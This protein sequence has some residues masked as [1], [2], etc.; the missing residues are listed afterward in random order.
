MDQ[1]QMDRIV[2]RVKKLFA[3][4]G[5]NPNENEAAAA[6]EK[7]QAILIE[8]NLSMTDITNSRIDDDMVIDQELVTSA[9]PW[10]RMLASAVAKMYFCKYYYIRMPGYKAVHN[11]VGE[12]HNIAVAKMMFIYLDQQIDRLAREGAKRFPASE[13]S[14]YRS[15]FRPACSIRVSDRIDARIEAA[16]RGEVGAPGTALAVLDLYSQSQNRAAAF[17]AASGIKPKTRSLSV[18]VKHYAGTSEGFAA[19]DKIGLDGQV[20]GSAPNGKLIQ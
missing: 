13:R 1:V 4:A 17:L 14:N 9:Y 18:H 12:K 19:G 2:E 15:S 7:A 8:H 11:F 3:L 20:T 6:A 10:R 5:N 16:K